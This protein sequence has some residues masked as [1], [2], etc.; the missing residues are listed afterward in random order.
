MSFV[1][2]E[3]ESPFSQPD[4]TTERFKAGLLISSSLPSIPALKLPVETIWQIL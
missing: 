3:I 1:K 4:E 2:A